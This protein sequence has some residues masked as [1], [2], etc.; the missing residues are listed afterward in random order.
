M[1]TEQS[2]IIRVSRSHTASFYIRAGTQFLQGVTS[3]DGSEKP[4]YDT[5]VVSAL[6]AAIPT[7]A[8]VAGMLEKNEVG[9][10]SKIETAYTELEFGKRPQL[11]VTITRNPKYVRQSNGTV[12][13]GKTSAASN[14]DGSARTGSRP[15]SRGS[16]PEQNKNAQK[17]L[18]E[19]GK[20]EAGP[21]VPERLGSTKLEKKINKVKKEG[22]KRGVE[23]EGAADM[24]G[25]KYFCTKVLE[26]AGDLDMLLESVKA[27]NAKSDPSEEERKGG[28]GKVGKTVW[29]MADQND[30]CIVCYVPPTEDFSAK[31]WLDLILQK[32]EVHKDLS[33]Q[34]DDSNPV[35]AQIKLSNNEGKNLFCLKLR[36]YVIQHANK[37]LVEKGLVPEIESDEEEMIFGDDD[38]DM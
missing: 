14:A 4:I 12:A 21:P 34:R 38:F 29:S 22:G 18:K 23:I 20:F 11:L 26:P 16:S 7:A 33:K 17:N 10:I 6:G 30:L 1:V 9:K 19:K 37:I 28:S 8:Q 36:D 31:E 15:N 32:L 13:N 5:I 24:G 25:V 3:K 27:M 35:Y 2:N